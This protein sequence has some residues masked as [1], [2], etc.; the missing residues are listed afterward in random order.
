MPVNALDHLQHI[1][2]TFSSVRPPT[3]VGCRRDPAGVAGP[4]YHTSGVS[5]S[6]RPEA[7]GPNPTSHHDQGAPTAGLQGM[8]A[9]AD[10]QN[11]TAEGRVS[12][13][14]GFCEPKRQPLMHT[15]RG[16]WQQVP[17]RMAN[18]KTLVPCCL[19]VDGVCIHACLTAILVLRKP[20][21]APPNTVFV[22]L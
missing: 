13:T 8:P 10:T 18:G 20:T 16:R 9:D 17:A 6:H 14:S 2:R 19:V 21:A 15:C 5:F 4:G 22:F 1:V 11:H 7:L 3:G 12:C